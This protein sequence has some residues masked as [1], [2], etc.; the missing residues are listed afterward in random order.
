MH[1][2][3]IAT[4]LI[5]QVS[6]QAE[7]LGAVGV[8]EINLRMGVLSGIARSLYFCW[9]S[10]SRNTLCAGARLNIDEVPL[11]VHCANCDDVKTPA[12]LYN[13]RCPDCGHPTPKVLTGR[14]MQLISIGLV[15]P[16]EEVAL[17]RPGTAPSPYG[18]RAGP[19]A[20]E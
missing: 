7:K 17:A 8:A 15:P 6:D 16:S 2:M 10:A 13:F 14:E 5:E 20:P 18:T 9:P 4:A 12:A 19:G 1:E 3:T 11:T